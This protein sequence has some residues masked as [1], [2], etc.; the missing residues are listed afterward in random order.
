MLPKESIFLE[1]RLAVERKGMT[2]DTVQQRRVA[3]V[4]SVGGGLDVGSLVGGGISEEMLRHKRIRL[5]DAGS[6]GDD[7][8][9]GPSE[10]KRL[11]FDSG[12]SSTGPPLQSAPR[13]SSSVFVH[14]LPIEVASRVW[15]FQYTAPKDAIMSR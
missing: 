9:S 8:N 5:Y 12:E 11:L 1:M 2:V 10:G 13:D 7:S 14:A 15:E 6:A 3:Y 4:G